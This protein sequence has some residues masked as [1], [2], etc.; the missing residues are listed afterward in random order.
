M[1]VA[2]F[3]VIN[4]ANKV[5][6]FE[7]TFLVA[8]FSPDV[9]LRILF[10]ILSG[11]NVDFLKKEL[12]WRSYTIEELFPTSKQVK[13]VEKKEFAAASLNLGHKI[14]VIHIASF[15]SLSQE[16]NIHPFRRMQIAVL[17]ANEAPTSIPI[18]YSDFTDIFSPKLASKLS[19][20]SKINDHAIEL[21]DN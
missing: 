8:N 14:F 9:V 17:V 5:R 16:D 4:Q 3:T 2:A 10:L 7:K 21:V 13:L 18:E 1:V 20:Y 19:K 12:Q 11:V 6:F 15:A